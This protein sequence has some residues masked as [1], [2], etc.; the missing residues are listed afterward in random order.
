MTGERIRRKL[1]DGGFREHV[2]YRC[3]NN[4]PAGDHPPLRWRE[5]D[6]EGIILE[7]FGS[8]QMPPDIAEWFRAT[9]RAAFSDVE[10]LQQQRK[11]SLAKRRT[12][13]AGMQTV[14]STATFREPSRKRRS[15][16][17]RRN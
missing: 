17:K 6:L 13:L 9:I 16:R 10:E 15:T 2:C 8:F 1:L 12:E 5:E 11:Q 7:E 14:F 3:A 4:H